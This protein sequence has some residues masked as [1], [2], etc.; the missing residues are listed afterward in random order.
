[1]AAVGFVVA[2]TTNNAFVDALRLEADQV[3]DFS[4]VAVAFG[5]L[6]VLELFTGHQLTAN[7][8]MI[9]GSKVSY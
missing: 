1:M 7:Y 5:A 2:D 8:Y 9:C 6:R 4:D 3:E